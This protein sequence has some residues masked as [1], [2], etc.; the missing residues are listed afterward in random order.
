MKGMIVKD[1]RI[2]LE[3]KSLMILGLICGIICL[4]TMKD[5]TFLI[6]YVTLIA[7]SMGCVSCAYDEM[8]NGMA[9]LMTMP[10]SRTKYVIEKYL[11]AVA[12]GLIGWSLSIGLSFAYL[13]ANHINETY[14]IMGES[15]GLLALVL[16]I[17][18]VM[19]PMVL[20]FGPARSR[21]MIYILIGIIFA[22]AGVMSLTHLSS[23]TVVKDEIVVYVIDYTIT[24]I[25]RTLVLSA[26]AL[27]IIIFVTSMLI[28]IGI[29]K[30]KEY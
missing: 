26:L 28:S 2:L 24:L 13:F 5:P 1:L 22:A 14:L 18:A 21:I 29:L 15:L 23:I 7:T 6:G 30:K 10:C 4:F 8:N 25:P 20:K 3:Q 27:A 12:I 17:P 9:Y 19:I 11:F 16:T